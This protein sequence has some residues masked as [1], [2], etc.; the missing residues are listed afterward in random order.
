HITMNSSIQ[1]M[2]DSSQVL[3]GREEGKE[4]E[5]MTKENEIAREMA[6]TNP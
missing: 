5:K 4:Q 2:K 3:E 1:T 6:A